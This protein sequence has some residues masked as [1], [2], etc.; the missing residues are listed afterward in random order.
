MSAP[1][2]RPDVTPVN[3]GYVVMEFSPADAAA[4][5]PPPIPEQIVNPD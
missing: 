4:L 3:Q 1:I 5:I 2:L